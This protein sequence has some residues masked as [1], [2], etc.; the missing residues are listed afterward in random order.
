MWSRRDE[1]PR[2]TYIIYYFVRPR[3]FGVG[4]ARGMLAAAAAGTHHNTRARTHTQNTLYYYIYICY[5]AC[6]TDRVIV[7]VRDCCAWRVGE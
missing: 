5:T 2:R 7:M 1:I 3:H 4:T 6:A